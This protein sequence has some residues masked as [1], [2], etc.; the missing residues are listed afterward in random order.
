[1]KLKC[2]RHKAK[3]L[4]DN[5]F[6]W[7]DRSHTECV[8]STDPTA[9]LTGMYFYSTECLKVLQ[10]KYAVTFATVKL[11]KDNRVAKFQMP[12]LLLSK[13]TEMLDIYCSTEENHPTAKV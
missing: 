10:N 11:H 2:D 13:L 9:V 8:Q 7:D 5:F 12:L 4:L 6:V 3:V 1:M